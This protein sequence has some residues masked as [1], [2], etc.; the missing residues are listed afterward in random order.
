MQINIDTTGL[1]KFADN[2][3][4][5]V[6]ENPIGA[7]MVGSA[8]AAVVTKLMNANTA[9]KNAKSWKKEVDRRTKKS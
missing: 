6:Q 3:S 9:R 4:K 7:L 2:L 1:K 5:Q 8:A